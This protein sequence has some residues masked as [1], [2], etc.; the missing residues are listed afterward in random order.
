MEMMTALRP[1]TLRHLVLGEG[2]LIEG[3][4]PERGLTAEGLTAYVER[5]GAVGGLLGVTA[6]GCF[7]VRRTFHEVRLAGQT[8]PVAGLRVPAWTEASLSGELAEVSP[9]N[10]TR[11]LGMDPA[12]TA[13]GT[14]LTLPEAVGPPDLGS[15]CW[16]GDTADGGRLLIC[17]SHAVSAESPRLAF[18]RDGHAQLSFRFVAQA[19][20]EAG[21]E[22]APFEVL[23]IDPAEADP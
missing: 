5:A 8:G 4:R 23:R 15:L 18:S 1:E 9:E 3:L 20:A 10:L 12:R 11:L 13:G 6:K 7:E 14:A 22:E 21:E 16:I 2:V 19:G 17:L